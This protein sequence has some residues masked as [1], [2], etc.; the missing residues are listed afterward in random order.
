[1]PTWLCEV[2]F[3]EETGDERAPENC[4]FS[5][6]PPGSTETA[7]PR[8]MPFLFRVTYDFSVIFSSHS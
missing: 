5:P 2:V 3:D 4:S 7:E 1:M 6:V 8:S